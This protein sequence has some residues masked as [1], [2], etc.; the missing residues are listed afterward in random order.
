MSFV[1]AACPRA[2]RGSKPK[3]ITVVVSADLRGYVEP[4][5]CSE[6]MLGGL[7]RAAAQVALAR[8][9]TDGV[10]FAD[11]GDTLFARTDLSPEQIP[12]AERKAKAIV[13][14]FGLM[15]ND[16]FAVGERDLARGMPFLQS[17]GIRVM[18]GAGHGPETAPSMTLKDVAGVKVA[19]VS[20][21]GERAAEM[22]KDAAANARSQGAEIVVAL[23]HRTASEASRLADRVGKSGI[24]AMVAGHAVSDLDG[25]QNRVIPAAVP[26]LQVMSKGRSLARFDFVVRPGTPPGFAQVLS[27]EQRREEIAKLRERIRG[28]QEVLAGKDL[29]P[30]VRAARSRQVAALESRLSDQ[31]S[32]PPPPPED[33]STLSYRFVTLS[34]GMPQDEK[35]KGVL[36][37]YNEDTAALNLSWAKA[38]GKDCAPARPG[39]SSFVGSGESCWTCHTEAFAVWKKTGHAHAYRTLEEKS[40]QYDLDC[41]R[42][43]VTGMNAAGGVCRVDK[44]EGRKD[45]QCEACHGPASAHEETPSRQNIIA[46]PAEQNCRVCHTAENSANFDFATYLPKILGVGHGKK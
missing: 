8:K 7:P 15:G 21:G 27:D 5:G 36:A 28:E 38:N 19:L 2:T 32:G 24:D 26:V 23:V 43:H 18:L 31:E 3:R 14:A 16:G 17:I 34:E 1:A 13:E 9:E 35:V 42:C 37:R 25:E 4:C 41:V 39:L 10:V 11:A 12:Q 22:L 44:V 29:S 46:K 20:A 45:V 33:R 30:E 40:K 6:N